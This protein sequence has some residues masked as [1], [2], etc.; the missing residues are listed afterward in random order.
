VYHSAVRRAFSA[1]AV[2]WSAALPAATLVSS[3]AAPAVPLY[4]L[5]LT[6]YAVGAYVCHQRPERSFFLWTRQM[7]VCAR[8]AG[9][10]IG[11]AIAVLGAGAIP[12]RLRPTREMVAVAALPIAL[13]LVYEWTTGV[14]PSN[15]IRAITGVGFG[16]AV[17]WLVVYKVK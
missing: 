10:Y 4:L 5:S 13:S 1:A 9:I 3:L 14:T 11:A 2:L 15:A 6:V 7:P 17:A 12:A 16:A 8:C